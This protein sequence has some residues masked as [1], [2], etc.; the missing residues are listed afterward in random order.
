M[1]CRRGQCIALCIGVVMSVTGC[2][3]AQMEKF[4][5]KMEET[6]AKLT[7]FAEETH[8][9]AEPVAE[10]TTAAVQSAVQQALEALNRIYE[11]SGGLMSDELGE[12]IEKK[13]SYEALAR[14][15]PE[16]I[17][18]IS[19][20][21]ERTGVSPNYLLALAR[22][23]SACN[24][25]A[26]SSTSSAAG[27]FQFTDQTWLIS[28]NEHASKYD[29]PAMSEAVLV[30]SSGRA[31]IETDSQDLETRIWEKRFEPLFSA[32]MAA[33]LAKANHDYLS[34]RLD[35]NKLSATDLYMA[36]FLGPGGAHKF[37]ISLKSEPNA[38]AATY[39]PSAAEANRYVFYKNGDGNARSLT[40]VHTFFER[41]LESA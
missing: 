37:L 10:R 12:P 36:H 9:K 33:E 24:S 27:M 28:V 18:P 35:R 34:R 5:K 32:Y 15:C 13:Q 1:R 31:R 6:H 20:A 2:Q 26:E 4:K 21:A 3:S 17:D 38:K 30:T 25:R 7:D 39:F 16:A 19:Q 8:R 41:K 11:Q 22:Q 14:N 40:E 29:E 23:E